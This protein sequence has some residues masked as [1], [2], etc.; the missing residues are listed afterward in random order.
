[1]LT[2]E[3]LP[4]IYEP[5]PYVIVAKGSLIVKLKYIFLVAPS[6]LTCKLNIVEVKLTVGMPQIVPLLS[7]ILNPNG[8]A[9]T[10]FHET[11]VPLISVG[12]I[13]AIIAPRSNMNSVCS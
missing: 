10:T 2:S 7:P 12:T 6:L 8:S 5:F 13:G 4:T 11:I 1:M 3:S 9:G